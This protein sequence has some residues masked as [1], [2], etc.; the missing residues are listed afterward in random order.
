MIFELKPYPSYKPSGIE[1]L[2]DVPEHWPIA[3]V[4]RYYSIQLGKMLQTQPRDIGDR[5]VHYLK[6]KNIQWFDVDFAN[7][8][9]MYASNDEVVQFGVKS[10]D[11]LVCEGGEGGRCALMENM[12]IEP[13]VI[14]N[15]LHRVRTL[16]NDDN[17]GTNDYLQYVLSIASS[18]G[19]FNALSE[20]STIAHFTAEKFKAL[21]VP[22]PSLVEQ[23]VIT[24]FLDHKTALI[25]RL[26]EKKQKKIKLLE[27][28]KQ[29]I[30]H[31]A[32]TGRIDV[33]TGQPYPAYKPSGIEWLG[34]VPEH[35]EACRLRNLSGASLSNVDK[36]SNDDESSVWLCN[37]SDVYHNDRIHA[38]MDFM[39][40]TATEKEIDRFQIAAG[41]V[42]ITKD[43]ETWNDIGV[44]SLVENAKHKLLCGYHLALLRPIDDRVVGKYMCFAFLSQ[45]VSSQLFVCANGVTRFGLSHNAIKSVWLPAP[46]ISEQAAIADFLDNALANIVKIT[47]YTKRQ[48]ELIR[49]YRNR[50]IA[51]AV[52]GRI[53]VRE[54]AEGLRQTNSVTCD[55][56]AIST[57]SEQHY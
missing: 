25:D 9:M 5:Q 6:A 32:V 50:L 27:E 46:S 36:H 29:A 34:D 11:L 43:S 13:L 1:W 16:S 56:E 49:E 37:Y 21:A 35:W 47:D 53:D 51:D 14:Q 19:W 28:Y 30:I 31:Q 2:G 10:G 8:D 4:K 55:D 40:A 54:A 45:G 15:A 33:R 22:M 23:N 3:P 52:T 38:N 39:E 57:P 24:D 42:L 17:M 48:I 12:K 26:I 20:K 18:T 7:V 44:P 41:D